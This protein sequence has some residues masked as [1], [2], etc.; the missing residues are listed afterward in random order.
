MTKIHGITSGNC[1]L[2]PNVFWGYW[3][4]IMTPSRKIYLTDRDMDRLQKMIAIHGR[5]PKVLEL[6]D[7]LNRATVVPEELIPPNVVTMNSRVRFEDIDA[8][9]KM[10]VTLVYPKDA[11]P[12]S[13]RI[14]I[15][16]P[17]G[18]AMLGL[19]VGQTIEWPL[20][21]GKVKRLKVLSVLYQPEA[22]GDWDL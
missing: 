11:T 14:S 8:G 12:G 4:F 5:D 21:E 9:K 3:F 10:D 15:M 6:Q 1:V 20:P 16:S 17:E 13:D 2:D 22:S 19:S 7:E 18:M